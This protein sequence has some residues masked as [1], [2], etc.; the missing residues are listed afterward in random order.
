[1]H[2]KVIEITRKQVLV[3]EILIEGK[4]SSHTIKILY[5]QKCWFTKQLKI[6]DMLDQSGPSGS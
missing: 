1:M 6:A 4:I 2:T 5:L 3:A